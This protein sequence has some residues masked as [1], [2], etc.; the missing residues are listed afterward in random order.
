MNV[1]E[2]ARMLAQSGLR[3]T[4]LWYRYRAYQR[5][6]DW[7]LGVDTRGF[8]DRRDL[9]INADASHYEPAPYRCLDRS[10]KMLAQQYRNGVFIDYGCGKGRVVVAAATMPF[11]KVIGVEYHEGLAEA[12][13]DNA[14]RARRRLRAEVEIVTADAGK[15]RVPDDANMIFMFNPFQGSTMA[16]VLRQLEASLLREPRKLSLL[17]MHP[18]DQVN[19]LE[20]CTWLHARSE[21][22]SSPLTGQTCFWHYEHCPPANREAACLVAAA[23]AI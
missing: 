3:E 10:L 16:A 21:L 4:I 1:R 14:H 15:Y 2:A 9:P 23:G 7:R 12:A 20:L 18:V 19:P 13:R 6:R 5:Y 17:Y 8:I 11:R 22:D